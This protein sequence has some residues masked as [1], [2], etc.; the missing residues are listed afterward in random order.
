MIQ[1]SSSLARWEICQ[2]LINSSHLYPTFFFWSSIL[3]ILSVSSLSSLLLILHSG[4]IFLHIPLT[5]LLSFSHTNTCIQSSYKKKIS[6][7]NSYKHQ[8]KERVNSFTLYVG[9]NPIIIIKSNSP[10]NSFQHLQVTPQYTATRLSHYF[11]I[12]ITQFFPFKIFLPS[13][14]R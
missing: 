13:M 3:Y 1:W 2:G 10:F 6:A 7:K 5:S 12:S 8:Y 11:Q 9:A 4:V 14:T